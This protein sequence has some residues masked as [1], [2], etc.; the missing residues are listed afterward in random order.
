V[1]WPLFAALFLGAAVALSTA[2]VEPSASVDDATSATRRL[3]GRL[4]RVGAVAFAVVLV[5]MVTPV[6]RFAW[7]TGGASLFP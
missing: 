5:A 7:Q 2:V 1:G 4:G 3:E 6:A